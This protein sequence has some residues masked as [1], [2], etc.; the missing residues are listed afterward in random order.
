MVKRIQIYTNILNTHTQK[1]RTHSRTHY[2]E[3]H[4]H[5]KFRDS[6]ALVINCDQKATCVCNYER[7]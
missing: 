5:T 7:Q 3:T 6:F 2:I 1:S 4:T